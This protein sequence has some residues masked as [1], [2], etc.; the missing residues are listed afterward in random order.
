MTWETEPRACMTCG[1]LMPTEGYM[2]QDGAVYCAPS[3]AGYSEEE[4]DEMHDDNDDP[5]LF[6]TTWES[7]ERPHPTGGQS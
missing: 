7:E 3:C 5:A 1:A 6:W 2:D 4:Y